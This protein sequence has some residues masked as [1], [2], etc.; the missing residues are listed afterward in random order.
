MLKSKYKSTIV[1]IFIL[2]LFSIQI[3]SAKHAPLMDTIITIDPG[4]GKTDY[5]RWSNANKW[6][7]I[8][9][10]ICKLM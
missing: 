7:N 5:T 8:Y 3:I 9:C 4:H 6:L 1:I 10:N 2:L